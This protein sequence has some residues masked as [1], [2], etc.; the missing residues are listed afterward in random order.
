MTLNLNK[1]YRRSHNGT[2]DTYDCLFKDFPPYNCFTVKF[3]PSV[4][5]PPPRYDEMRR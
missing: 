1:Q 3:P 2:D 4:M 5:S